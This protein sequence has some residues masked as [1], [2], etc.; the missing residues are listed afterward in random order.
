MVLPRLEESRERRCRYGLREHRND[1]H[2][3]GIHGA[4]LLG[5]DLVDRITQHP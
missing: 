2:Q 4:A 1:L 3:T 5:P